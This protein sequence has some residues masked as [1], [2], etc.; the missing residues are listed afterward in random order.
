[1]LNASHCLKAALAAATLSLCA[2]ATPPPNPGPDY[3]VVRFS[4]DNPDE[5]LGEKLDGK[6][7]SDGRTFKIKAG[8]HDLVVIVQRQDTNGKMQ[9]CFT[10]LHYAQF[11]DDEVYNIH[12]D[13]LGS[14]VFLQL[15][16]HTDVLATNTGGLN[17]SPG[18]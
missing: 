9:Y 10:T 5:V 1:M 13:R 8:S 16:R 15:R 14:K 3:S 12:E 6:S 11:K 18:S 7:T 4:H 2:C 17:C